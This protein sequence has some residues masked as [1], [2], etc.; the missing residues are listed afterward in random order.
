MART[1]IVG[2]LSYVWLSSENFM[3]LENFFFLILFEILFVVA[4]ISFLRAT[5]NGKFFF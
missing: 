2:V 5:K 1:Q 4:V 3:L